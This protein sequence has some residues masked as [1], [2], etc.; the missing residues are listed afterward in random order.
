VQFYRSAGGFVKVSVSSSEQL[1][2]CRYFVIQISTAVSASRV[3]WGCC[4]CWLWHASRFSWVWQWLVYVW[5][6]SKHSM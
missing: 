2:S 3:Y 1:L 4:G 5:F 6:Y